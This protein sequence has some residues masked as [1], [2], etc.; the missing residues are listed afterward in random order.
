MRPARSRSSSAGSPPVTFS[1]AITASSTSSAVAAASSRASQTLPGPHAD[2]PRSPARSCRPRRA[3]RPPPAA[4]RRAARRARARSLVAAHELDPQRRQVPRRRGAQRGVVVEDLA[5]ELAQPR[6]R[7]EPEVVGQ[8]RAH[9]LI[10]RERVGLAA[11]PVERGDQQRPQALAVG[12]A[13]ERRL[14][15]GDH[16]LPEP[17]PRRELRLEQLRARLLELHA[18]RR[19]P[20]SRPRARR[21]R[22]LERGR[23]ERAGT[24]LVTRVEPPRGGRGVAQHPQR[25]DLRRVHGQPV[26]PV[27]QRDRRARAAAA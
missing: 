17:Q 27:D 18:V 10:G 25:V 6:A 12:R 24:V 8:P 7:V 2:P 26:G 4:A 13:R 23:A 3:R 22:Q 21:G 20:V 14:E 1:A 19:R 5:F 11:R 15:L 16:R 9:P